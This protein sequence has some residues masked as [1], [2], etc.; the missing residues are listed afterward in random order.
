MMNQ[1]KPLPIVAPVAVKAALKQSELFLKHYAYPQVSMPDVQIY[2]NS[3]CAT[4]AS[5]RSDQA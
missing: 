1:L 4:S 3:A 5:A 2:H